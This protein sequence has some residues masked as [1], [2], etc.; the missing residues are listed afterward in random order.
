MSKYITHDRNRMDALSLHVWQ[1]PERLF[2]TN[3]NVTNET[4]EHFWAGWTLKCVL[5]STFVDSNAL[6]V[7]SNELSP[8]DCRF[9]CITEV[10]RCALACSWSIQMR[11]VCAYLRSHLAQ[12]DP[13]VFL[14]L[15]D[16]LLLVAHGSKCVFDALKWNLA[17]S[18]SI[19]TIL[20][21]KKIQ[22]NSLHFIFDF[23]T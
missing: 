11:S 14:V 3:R 15:L 10:L 7:C 4:S 23:M 1:I 13:D 5:G 18:L 6:P 9:K 16:A 22:R 8:D 21:V 2:G 20:Y 17:R 19:L 12:V